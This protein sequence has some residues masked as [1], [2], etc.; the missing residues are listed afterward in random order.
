MTKLTKQDYDILNSDFKV[1]IFWALHAN[2]VPAFSVTE[3]SR[4][5]A[6]YKHLG[7]TLES[8]SCGHCMLTMMQIIGKEYIKYEEEAAQMKKQLEDLQKRTKA[9]SSSVIEQTDASSQLHKATVIIEEPK[10]IITEPELNFTEEEDIANA[11][12]SSVIEQTDASS[13]LHNYGTR[14]YSTDG[15]DKE[16]SLSEEC[17]I[18]GNDGE[19]AG[20]KAKTKKRSNRNKKERIDE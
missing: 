3:I 8:S 16:S 6:I 12:S 18:S 15:Q 1:A 10:P 11:P 19:E 9:T 14:D 4:L 17:I 13:Q 7:H 20:R 5:R 2:C